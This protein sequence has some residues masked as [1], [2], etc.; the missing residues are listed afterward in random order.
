MYDIIMTC[1]I[2]ALVRKWNK[3]LKK[4]EKTKYLLKG[5]RFS[6]K[7]AFLINESSAVHQ[8]QSMKEKQNYSNSI[9]CSWSCM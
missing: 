9:S 6:F 4:K 8:Y 5:S 2:Y 1:I 3:H 7:D